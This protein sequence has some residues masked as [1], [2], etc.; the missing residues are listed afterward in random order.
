MKK[1]ISPPNRSAFIDKYLAAVSIFILLS[2]GANAQVF[3]NPNPGLFGT[4]EHRRAPDSTLYFPTGCGAP[5]GVAS[6]R[7]YG[8]AGSGQVLK[9]A[10]KYYDSCGHHEYVWDPSLQAWHV[11][12]SS[13]GGSGNPNSN[14]GLGYRFAIPGTNNI[15]TLHKGYGITL[16][17][18]SNANEITAAMDTTVFDTSFLFHTG[19]PSAANIWHLFAQGG[20][21]FDKVDTP[22][23]EITPFTNSDSTI[24]HRL[25]NNSVANSKLVGMPPGTLKGN[26]IG[27]TTTLDLT[28]AQATQLLTTASLTANGILPLAPHNGMKPVMVGGIV[29][30]GD[31]TAAG[32]GGSPN[33]NVGSGYRLAVASTNNIKTLFCVGCAFDSV[34][35][36]NAITLTVSAVGGGVTPAQLN[37]NVPSSDTGWKRIFCIPDIDVSGGTSNGAT[38]NWFIL[39]TGGNHGQ[40]PDMD[41]DLY[42]GSDGHLR[43]YHETALAVA[44]A[45]IQDDE[46]TYPINWGVIYNADYVEGIANLSRSGLGFIAHGNGTN[47]WQL[48]NAQLYTYSVSGNTG[49]APDSVPIAG[50]TELKF[51]MPDG[52][53]ANLG[54]T[55]TGL[56]ASYIGG[57]G[58]TLER[59]S[60]APHQ[61]N[62]RLKDAA[63]GVVTGYPQ[64]G[65]S[66][67]ITDPRAHWEQLD[68]RQFL[69]SSNWLFAAGLSNLWFAADFKVF[70]D[71]NRIGRP[72]LAAVA[73]GTAGQINLSWSRVTNDVNGYELQRSTVQNF[74]GTVTTLV[75]PIT[76]GGS[77][78]TSFNDT[79]LTTGTTYYYRLRA[80]RISGQYSAHARRKS[81]VAP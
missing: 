57:N 42:V 53:N 3:Q 81:A 49:A 18:I 61:Y 40:A 77:L 22:S 28:G 68:L 35:N 39:T 33:S 75:N 30:W 20:A 66:I 67:L 12:D 70:P 5:S 46:V 37:K 65:D 58:Y 34:S 63:G 16:D 76:L 26:N 52:A 8:F 11:S 19:V 59:F 69:T 47:T 51:D 43:V 36:T 1:D 50:N 60:S 38:M 62:F 44:N 25:N 27:S 71:S 72:V 10:A 2:F 14:V 21:L 15:K 23:A 9:Q 7:S 56:N 54:P 55:I 6:L 79:G 24:G 29:A 48:L 31:T 73:S 45:N 74:S 80:S 32:G 4:I 64:A 17:S 78:V 13:G 41:S